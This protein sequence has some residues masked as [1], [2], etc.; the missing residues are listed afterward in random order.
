MNTHRKIQGTP[1]QNRL[2]NALGG[3]IMKEI[4]IVSNQGANQDQEP[5]KETI[6]LTLQK[7][8]LYHQ[9][10]Q[11]PNLLHSTMNAQRKHTL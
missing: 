6:V 9:I 2:P 10:I 4:Q 5:Q 1:K 8:L 7:Q 11:E 3:K